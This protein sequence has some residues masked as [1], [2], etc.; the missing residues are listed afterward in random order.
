[1][2]RSKKTNNENEVS[3]S[4]KDDEIELLLAV[5]INFK[6]EKES[7][8]YD[9]ESVKTKYESITELFV[10]NYPKTTSDKFLKTNVEAEFTKARVLA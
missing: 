1:M 6:A 2:G 7:E 8:G 4:W 9:W 5:I 10:K 3:F